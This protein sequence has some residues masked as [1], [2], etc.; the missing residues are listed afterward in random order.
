M[1]MIA[2]KCDDITVTVVDLNETRIA[3]WNSDSLPIYEPGLKEVVE[4]CRGK[5]LFFTT[6]LTTSLKEADIIFISVGTP[7]KSHGMGGGAAADL[8]YIESCAR[9]IAETCEN[10]KIIVEKSTVPVR[11]AALLRSIFKGYGKDD[12]FDIQC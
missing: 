12:L 8:V 1:A 3:A 6:D 7:T 4:N 10:K 11:T 9:T 2:E 5:N